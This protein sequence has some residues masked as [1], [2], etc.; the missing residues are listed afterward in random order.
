[1]NG[2]SVDT[3][4]RF[5]SLAEALYDGNKSALARA[6]DMQ[7]GSFTKYVQGERRP[8]ATVLKRLPRLGVNVNWLL[9]GEGPMLLDEEDEDAGSPSLSSSA[10]NASAADGASHQASPAYQ[11]VPL[12][13]VR[14]GA[15]G[16][17]MFDEIKE[18]ERIRKSFIRRRYDIEPERLRLFRISSTMMADTI[19]PGDRVRGVRLPPD[20]EVEGTAKNVYLVLGPTGVFATRL[21]VNGEVVLEGD[22]PEVDNRSLSQTEWDEN[23][24][25]IARVLEVVRPLQE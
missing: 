18:P 9:T 5:R 16:E 6:I 15:E 11:P 20:T 23:F 13:Q 8:G 25:P 1:M 19:R 21:H 3:G 4:E 22:N 24:N 2:D 17:L 7:P 14:V 12:V 10:G